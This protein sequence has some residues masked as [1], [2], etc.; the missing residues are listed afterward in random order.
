SLY[1]RSSYACEYLMEPNEVT[2]DVD[3]SPAHVRTA[4]VLDTLMEASSTRLLASPAPTMTYYHGL[5][6][7]RFVFSGFAPWD[8]ER[9]DAI[10]L[11]DFVLQDIWGLSRQTVDRGAVRGGAAGRGARPAVVRSVGARGTAGAR[12]GYQ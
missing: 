7:N 4:S 6:A 5:E 12:V 10:G 11:V 8:F 1:Y 3:L 2:E 9:G